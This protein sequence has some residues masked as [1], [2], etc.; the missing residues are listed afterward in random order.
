[1]KIFTMLRSAARLT[2]L[3]LKGP[4]NMAGNRVRISMRISSSSPAAFPF[5]CLSALRS[6]SPQGLHGVRQ[7]W[8]Y[9][10]QTLPNRLGAAGQV[11]DESPL[12]CARHR[13]AE[14]GVG[15]FLEALRPHH[16]GEP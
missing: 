11:D 3:S 6:L 7:G 14:H 10:L 15:R 9:R 13:T 8:H 16:L 5:L 4:W 12:A 2:M 1:M